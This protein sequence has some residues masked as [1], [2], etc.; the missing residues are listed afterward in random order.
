MSINMRNGRKYQLYLNEELVNEFKEKMLKNST[1][2]LSG[3]LC[4]AMRTM[5]GHDTVTERLIEFD[6]V[7]NSIKTKSKRKKKTP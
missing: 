3:A 6:E 1:M 2:S 7:L 4:E 5:L